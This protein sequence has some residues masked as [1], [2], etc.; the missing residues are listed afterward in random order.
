[1]IF[2]RSPGSNRRGAVGHFPK[3]G[4][5]LALPTPVPRHYSV[6]PQV[7]SAARR[8]MAMIRHGSVLQLVR[9]I[10]SGA[11]GPLRT[12]NCYNVSSTA[13]DEE[14]FEEIGAAVRQLASRCR[15][16]S[17][18]TKRM[19]KR[20][21]GHL[22]RPGPQGGVLRPTAGAGQ[23]A[24]RRCLPHGPQ[25]ESRG[26]SAAAARSPGAAAAGRRPGCGDLDGG[27]AGCSRGVGGLSDRHREPLVLC[28][29][30]GKTQDEAGAV[31]GLIERDAEE[32]VR[33]RAERCCAIVGASGGWVAG[34]ARRFGLAG[35]TAQA[36]SRHRCF[37]PRSKPRRGLGRKAGGPQPFGQGRCLNR[38]S[39][40]KHVAH[41]TQRRDPGD[42]VTP[43]RSPG[44]GQHGALPP[45]RRQAR[46]DIA[47]K[48]G[49]CDTRPPVQPVTAGRIRIVVLDPKGQPLPDADIHVSVWTDEKAFKHN[50]DF[51]TDAEGAAQVELP[52]TFSILRLSA[53]RKPYVQLF[54]GWE[55]A[56]LASGKGVP[57]EY[58][59]R[60][61]TA[62]TAGGRVL[63]D[64]GKPIVGARVQVR[65]ATSK[66]GPSDAPR[67]A[68]RSR[69]PW[70]ATQLRLDADG[71]SASTASRTI[72]GRN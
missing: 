2:C 44:D 66:A 26:C 46:S 58:T 11:C 17:S 33:K 64:N 15:W 41:Q 16:A 4:K 43:R 48:G 62:R 53:G 14:A 21:P 24:P 71:R 9:G 30:L 50:R 67:P 54:A 7:N 40:E 69:S 37:W 29:L 12:R 31:A 8:S 1:M 68:M 60:L 47:H 22:P 18:P 65:L 34:T 28:Y 51:V 55:K 6:W 59:F 10:L 57:P 70:G 72:R 5:K 39:A 23:L 25:G 61:E 49:G 32:A 38:G 20:L 63:D 27:P 35:A 3:F 45:W 36:V 42:R 13:H 56:E 52:K 19:P